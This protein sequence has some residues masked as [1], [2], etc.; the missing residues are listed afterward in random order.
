M[1]SAIQS[2][3]LQPALFVSVQFASTTVYVW[4]GN[5]S[6]SWNGHTWFGA[7]SLLQITMIEDG[8]NVEA[9]GIT[10]TLSGLDPSILHDFLEE[11]QIGMA[12]MVYL[13]AF[14]GGTLIPDPIVC[15]PARTDAPSID[16][17][18]DT[19][20]ISLNAETRLLEM[21]IAVDRRYTQ[22]DQQLDHPGD[23]GFNFVPG[24]QFT[25]IY[26]GATPFQGN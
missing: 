15:F 22:D 2:N 1:Q 7:G 6:I 9:R 19:I 4:S 11:Y 24:L 18:P 23:N 5:S 21:N 17:G 10:I 26:W 13:G 25:A 16:I 12:A 20:A 8:S 14:S 3:Q